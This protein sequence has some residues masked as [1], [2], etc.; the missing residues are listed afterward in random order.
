MVNIQSYPA[1]RTSTNY[2]SCAIR[3][4]SDKTCFTEICANFYSITKISQ[5]A[6]WLSG[7]LLDSRPR[8]RGF[9]PRQRHFVVVLEQDTFILA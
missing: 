6:Q 2:R 7:R 9:E 1:C 4:K 5:R 8:G 3:R